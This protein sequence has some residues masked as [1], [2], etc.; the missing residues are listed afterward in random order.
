MT[1]DA[2]RLYEDE[3]ADLLPLDRELKDASSIRRSPRKRVADLLPL[4]RELKAS[5]GSGGM[6][7]L[8]ALQT[9]SR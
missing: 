5:C 3:V 6:W 4:D 2:L 7:R 1:F 8:W 9:Y